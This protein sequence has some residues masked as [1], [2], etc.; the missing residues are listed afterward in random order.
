MSFLRPNG[1]SAV[2]SYDEANRLTLIFVAGISWLIA[3]PLLSTYF[4]GARLV[5]V[6][7][8]VGW[9]FLAACCVVYMYGFFYW[10]DD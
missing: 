1:V 2:Y 8:A 4:E 10:K 5:D 9:L 3:I 6:L 7:A